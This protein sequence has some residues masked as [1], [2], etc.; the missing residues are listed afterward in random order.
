MS[1]MQK[2]KEIVKEVEKLLGERD[3]IEIAM[4]DESISEMLVELNK[5]R[6]R[7]ELSKQGLAVDFPPAGTSGPITVYRIG[8]IAPSRSKSRPEGKEPKKRP[9]P[10]RHQHS[11][12]PPRIAKDIIDILADEGSHVIQLEGPTQCGKTTLVKFVA[13]E[14]GRK[15]YQVNCRGDMGSE[16]FLGEK[17]IVVDEEAKQN[18]IEYVAGVVEQAMTEGLDEDGNETGPAGVL[19]IDEVT[20]CPSHVA[21]VLNRVLESDDSRRSLFLDQDAGRVVRSHSQFRIILAGNTSG[22]GAQDV[23]EG[24]Y[25]AQLDGLDMSFLHRITA[26]FKMGYDKKAEK[27]ILAEKI[28]DDK[29]A[30]MVLEFRDAIRSHIKAGDLSTPF[31]TK[32]IVDI[33]NL[34]RIFGDLGKAIYY[35]VF[36]HLLPEERAVYN[37]TAVTVLGKD[38]LN[39][40]VE[41]DVDYM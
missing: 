18:K 17:T 1:Q 34:Y 33:A 8:A 28:G 40:Y 5:A 21:H 26:C 23:N 11:Y 3:R 31:S 41:E 12:V 27:H 15:L 19:F 25:T 29:I 9:V 20:A 30:Q 22:R 6:T 16:A 35:A 38:L 14:F 39:E 32:N 24:V 7:L 37:E 2:M 36:S 10:K 4:D 13:G